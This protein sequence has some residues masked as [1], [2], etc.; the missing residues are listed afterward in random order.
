MKTYDYSKLICG[1]LYD[2]NSSRIYFD[3]CNVLGWEERFLSKFGTQG[4]PLYAPNADVSRTMGVWFICRQT[5]TEP[6]TSKLDGSINAINY[7]KT[8]EH[9]VEHVGDKWGLAQD[10]EQRIVFSKVGRYY[11][12]RGVFQLTYNQKEPNGVYKREYKLIDKNYP[13]G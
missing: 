4:Q 12:F 9:I 11:I 10:G 7:F 8:N 3:C 6:N 2:S 5:Y 13:K 1:Q